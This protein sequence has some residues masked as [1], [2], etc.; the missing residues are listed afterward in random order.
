MV[1]ARYAL[2]CTAFLVV[3]FAL[4]AIVI[5]DAD[6]PAE[7]TP[8]QVEAFTEDNR[9][10][11]AVVGGATMAAGVFFARL[12]IDLGSGSWG[13]WPRFL[14][15]GLAVGAS[16]GITTY[17]VSAMAAAVWP[18]MMTNGGNEAFEWIVSFLTDLLLGLALLGFAVL[19][20]PARRMGTAV[21][22]LGALL[23]AGLVLAALMGAG[24][25]H[26]AQLAALAWS[27]TVGGRLLR[28]PDPVAR[29]KTPAEA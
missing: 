18:S 26:L 24:D 3:A 12:A 6:R 16:A 1:F 4:S 13:H 8:E 17:G 10:V 15:V 25:P 5:L 11:M 20:W 19:M 27:G 22:V 7:P 21:P 14:T 29:R 9:L 28:R 23:G 2:L